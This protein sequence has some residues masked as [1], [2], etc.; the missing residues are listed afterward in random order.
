VVVSSIE[1][2]TVLRFTARSGREIE[3]ALQPDSV[4]FVDDQSHA[5]VVSDS[6]RLP[7]PVKDDA[8]LVALSVAVESRQKVYLHAD[9]HGAGVLIEATPTASGWSVDILQAWMA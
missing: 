6:L 4:S 9:L 1:D 5:L 8:G 7:F 2:D 3:S